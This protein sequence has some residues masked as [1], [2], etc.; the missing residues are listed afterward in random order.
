MGGPEYIPLA[1]YHRYTEAEMEQRAAEFYSD[2]QR[3]RTVRDFSKNPVPRAVIEHCIMATG[4]A[5]SGANMQP[6]SFVAVSDAAVKRRIRIAA[7]QE[8]QEFY[9]HR[10]P[11]EWLDA[12]APLGTDPNKPFLETAPYLIAIFAQNYGVLPDGRQFKHY[13]ATESVGIATGFLLIALHN[14]GLATLTHTPSPMG[15]LN[16]ILGRPSNERPFLLIVAGYPSDDAT[17][18]KIT[19]KS[20]DEI[21]TFI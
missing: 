12:L 3:R 1:Q 8:E 19:K 7:E 20:L 18:P 17:V 10:A 13:Y 9:D 2:I 15:F 5:P 4:T 6:W 14:A 16:E 21:A 11:Q